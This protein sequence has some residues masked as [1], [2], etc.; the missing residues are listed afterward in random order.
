MNHFFDHLNMS[1]PAF[2]LVLSSIL[3]EDIVRKRK[4]RGGRKILYI[5][6]TSSPLP[7]HL[8]KPERSEVP[9]AQF[10]EL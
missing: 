8:P 6:R 1:V 7:P 10:H 4:V 3:A 2:Q 9:L 5:H